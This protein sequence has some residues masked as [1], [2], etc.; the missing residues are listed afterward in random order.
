[1]QLTVHV[2]WTSSHVIDI[3]DAKYRQPTTL[4]ELIALV[5][6]DPNGP[7]DINSGGATVSDWDVIVSVPPHPVRR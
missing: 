3:D 5:R 4:D 2:T 1:M 6:A 7:G